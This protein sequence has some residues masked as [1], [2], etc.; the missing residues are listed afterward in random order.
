MI[1]GRFL[2]RFGFVLDAQGGGKWSPSWTQIGPK[3]KTE[4]KMRKEALQ[5]R[6]GEV[7]GRS[8]SRLGTIWAELE[9]ILGR[10]GGVLGGQNRCFSLG[11]SILFETCTFRTKIVILAGLGAILGPL[12]AN[13]G[14]L[15][16][17]LDR[18]R[19]PRGPKREAKRDP[20]GAQKESKMSSIFLSIFGS[21]WERFG[22]PR[23]VGTQ[24][25]G[26]LDCAQGPGPLPVYMYI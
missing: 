10:F 18:F 1:F 23:G 20:R 4:K 25:F 17:N 15:G 26:L 19:R 12:G 11:F 2:V 7:L 5:N 13:L 16:P 21:I 24:D 3:S 9:A 22:G 14:P 8:W 6:L